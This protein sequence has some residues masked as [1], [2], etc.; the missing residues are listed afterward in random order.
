MLFCP[1]CLGKREPSDYLQDYPL[2]D[3]GNVGGFYQTDEPNKKALMLKIHLHGC[4]GV[5]LA[6]A[7]IKEDIVACFKL[8][9]KDW[10]EKI[11]NWAGR[12]PV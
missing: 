7:D 3:F 8:P 1:Y 11:G 10:A 4:G 6:I 2:D 12:Q 9:E 5:F